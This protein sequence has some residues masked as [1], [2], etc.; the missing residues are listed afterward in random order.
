MSL[1]DLAQKLAQEVLNNHSKFHAEKFAISNN[2]DEEIIVIVYRGKKSRVK[3]LEEATRS[4][5]VATL[6]SGIPCP[7]CGGRGKV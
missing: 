7:T 3:S 1:R 5:P 4:I 6:P 2:D